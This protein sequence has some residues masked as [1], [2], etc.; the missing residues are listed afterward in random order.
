MLQGTCFECNL[1]MVSKQ[2]EAAFKEQGAAFA[3]PKGSRDSRGSSL[4]Y[5]DAPFQVSRS[6]IFPF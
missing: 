3:S 2:G 4:I 5:T 6:Y 1:S